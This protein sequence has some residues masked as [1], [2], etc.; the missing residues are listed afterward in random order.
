MSGGWQKTCTT[1]RFLPQNKKNGKTGSRKIP[2]RIPENHLIPIVYSPEQQRL[3]PTENKTQLG[4][5]PDGNYLE[6][7]Q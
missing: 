1:T 3:S 2:G 4:V 7:R 6:K 5:N